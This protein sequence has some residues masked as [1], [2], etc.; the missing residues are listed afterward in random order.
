MQQFDSSIELGRSGDALDDS[1]YNVIVVGPVLSLNLW[2]IFFACSLHCSTLA[3]AAVKVTFS[4]VTR[5]FFKVA[6]IVSAVTSNVLKRKPLLRCI[7]RLFQEGAV[8]MSVTLTAPT[9][10][11]FQFRETTRCPV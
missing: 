11:L 2:W 5:T 7:D 10:T 8:T 6:T 3:A 1:F 9:M 4:R